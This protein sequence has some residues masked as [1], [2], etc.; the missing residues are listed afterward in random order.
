[1]HNINPFQRIDAV[2]ICCLFISRLQDRRYT[3]HVVG[4]PR[5]EL[6]ALL[7]KLSNVV[8]DASLPMWS[9]GAFSSQPALVDL[10]MPEL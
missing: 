7:H 3:P 10:V 8:A 1:M 4:D 5:D 9:T 2:S 6:E